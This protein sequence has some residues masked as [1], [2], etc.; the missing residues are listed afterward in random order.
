MDTTIRNLDERLYRRMRARALAAGMTV[1]EALNEAMRA[2][3]ALPD[4]AKTSSLRDLV[5]EPYPTGNE[6]LSEDI[7]AHVYG[8]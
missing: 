3:L 6:R 8:A 5:P 2:Y 1:G 7:D 4:C